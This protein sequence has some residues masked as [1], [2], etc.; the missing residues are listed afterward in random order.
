[1]PRSPLG[2]PSREEFLAWRENPV[3]QW[4][5]RA[6][7]AVAEVQRQGWTAASWDQGEANP[8]LLVELRSR[9]DAYR[10]AEETNYEAF[11]ALNE[12]DPE[13]GEEQ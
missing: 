9:A 11:C 2:Q 6:L 12:Q 3:S 1:M 13:A 5:F 7:Q 4:V 8:L 10:A